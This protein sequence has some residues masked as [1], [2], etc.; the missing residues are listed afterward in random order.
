MLQ[1]VPRS[2]HV[3]IQSDRDD[4]NQCRD[5][6]ERD[7]TRW[8]EMERDGTVSRKCPKVS[9]YVRMF[10]ERRKKVPRRSGSVWKVKW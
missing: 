1:D 9:E 2:D 6:S 10:R 5:M 8:N 3:L 4:F 7:G